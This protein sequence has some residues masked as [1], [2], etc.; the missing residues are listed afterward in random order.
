MQTLSAAIG[1]DYI[2]TCASQVNSSVTPGMHPKTPTALCRET[3]LLQ[4]GQQQG[5]RLQS[6]L[7]RR[8]KSLSRPEMNK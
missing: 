3:S 4:Q 1:K 6:A 2:I 5:L 7:M 8:Y